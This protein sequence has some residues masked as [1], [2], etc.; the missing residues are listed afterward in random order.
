MDPRAVLIDVSSIHDQKKGFISP[1]RG[2]GVALFKKNG[3]LP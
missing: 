2:G 1:H 3:T